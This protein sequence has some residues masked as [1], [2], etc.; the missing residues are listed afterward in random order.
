VRINK[1]QA[2]LCKYYFIAEHF[3][4]ESGAAEDMCVCVRVIHVYIDELCGNM[5]SKGTRSL[6]R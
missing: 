6:Y 5:G 1:P 3:F 4:A 2:Q